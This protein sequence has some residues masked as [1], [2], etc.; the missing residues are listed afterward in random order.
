[1]VVIELSVDRTE[2][3][4]PLPEPKVKHPFPRWA[5]NVVALLILAPFL[6]PS[7]T[8]TDFKPFVDEATRV[9]RSE[10][11]FVSRLEADEPGCSVAVGIDGRVAWAS[12][13]GLADLAS[14]TKL[15]ADTVFDI[16]SVSE[17]FTAAAILLLAEEGGLSVDDTVSDHL[18]GLPN[19]AERVTI[20]HLIHKTSGIRDY[21]TLLGN[22][23]YQLTQRTT[24]A[25]AIRALTDAPEL[26]FESGK[27]TDDSRS[28]YLLLTEIVHTVSGTALPRFL[29][30]RIFEPLGLEMV[31]TRTGKISGKATSYTSDSRGP[32]VTDFGWEQI[33]A[34]GIQTTP[35]ELVRWADNYRTGRVGGRP[36]LDAQLADAV[37]DTVDVT[38]SYGAGIWLVTDGSLSR[39]G[40][41]EGFVA[42]LEIMPDH[43]T[44][45]A[46]SCNSANLAPE[47]MTAIIDDLRRIWA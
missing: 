31:M 38:Y 8:S 16:A 35:S 33:G 42:Y 47:P 45:L 13:R 30:E 27:W 11:M 29:Q 46:L 22:Q 9:A 10:A 44:A 37:T 26:N 36:L 41:W 15:T 43:R 20:D 14:G 19:W 34:G 23:G 3:P 18:S 40:G 24:Q 25:Q 39:G 28:N 21:G 12:S 6:G 4:S 2:A 32:Q 5:V 17:Q 1:M 7:S